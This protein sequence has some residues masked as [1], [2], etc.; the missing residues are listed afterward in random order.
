VSGTKAG[1]SEDMA[2]LGGHF[3]V[4][5][6]PKCTRPGDRSASAYRV[7]SLELENGD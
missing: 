5:D 2:R 3:H 6:S 4:C 7:L 1:N